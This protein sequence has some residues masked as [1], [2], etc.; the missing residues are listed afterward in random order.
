MLSSSLPG[1]IPS[2]VSNTFKMIKTLDPLFRCYVLSL[3]VCIYAFLH[4]FQNMDSASKLKLAKDVKV[5]RP[6]VKVKSVEKKSL[7]SVVLVKYVFSVTLL[8]VLLFQ[9]HN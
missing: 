7:I 2:N 4:I 3:D 5:L 1:A 9:E 8:Q 6:E